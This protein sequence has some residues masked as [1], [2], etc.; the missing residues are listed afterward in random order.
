MNRPIHDDEELPLYELDDE[1]MYSLE[2]VARMS[3]L[4]EETILRFQK[5]GYVRSPSGNRF[6][7]EALRVLRHIDYLQNT[8]GVN[9]SGLRLILSLLNE[10]EDLKT[11]L[12][13][14][15]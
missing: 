14:K 11:L 1:T 6:D 15:H 9:D 2:V 4:N 8:C 10:L 12:R 7:N 13:S 3:G 5:Q